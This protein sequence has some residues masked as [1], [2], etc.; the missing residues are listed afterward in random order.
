MSFGECQLGIAE[1]QA[2]RTAY[3]L[4]L[5]TRNDAAGQPLLKFIAQTK[6]YSK[7]ATE[8]ISLLRGT[9]ILS[10]LLQRS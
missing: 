10:K 7:Q 5:H 3:D 1:F 8:I 2:G 9:S 6:L 4:S